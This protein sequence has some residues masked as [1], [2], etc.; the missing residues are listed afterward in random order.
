M[1]N[2][3][4]AS[5]IIFS[6]FSFATTAQ[7]CDFHGAGYGS[8]GINDAPW[9]FS[10]FDPDYEAAYPYGQSAYPYG[11]YGQ[12][13]QLAIT[14]PPKEPKQKAKPSFSNVATR[15]ATDAKERLAD[16]DDEQKPEL[17][18]KTNQAELD[19]DS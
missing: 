1:K 13:H 15:V 12:D 9:L 5:A 10:T 14:A 6:S 2:V 4:L 8:I 7:A 19:T 17:Q 16:Q 11:Q 18:A 3:V